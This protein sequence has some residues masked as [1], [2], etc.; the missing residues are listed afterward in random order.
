MVLRFGIHFLRIEKKYISEDFMAIHICNI[1]AT[2]LKKNCFRK[3]FDCEHLEQVFKG[4][5]INYHF[6]A[7]VRDEI[8]NEF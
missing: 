4:I 7:I 5:Y 6:N 1:K 3:I 8:I 2:T